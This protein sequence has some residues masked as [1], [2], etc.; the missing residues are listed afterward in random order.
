MPVRVIITTEAESDLLAITDWI[1]G[2]S[3]VNAMAVAR[4]LRAKIAT[5][6]R[7]PRSGRPAAEHRFTKHELRQLSHRPYRIVYAIFNDTVWVLHVRHG[8][9]RFLR[10]SELRIDSIS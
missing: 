3:P 8:S 10:R 7:Y 1:A 9:Q 5:L 6:R 2:D 4:K